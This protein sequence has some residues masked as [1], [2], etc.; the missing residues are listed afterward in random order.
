MK[1]LLML[2]LEPVI[3]QEVQK[4]KYLILVLM[5]YLKTS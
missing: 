1:K 4:K 3:L 2:I 5:N